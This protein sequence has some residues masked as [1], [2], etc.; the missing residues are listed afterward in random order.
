MISTLYKIEGKGFREKEAKFV[1]RGLS[2]INT[3]GTAI[4][5]GKINL[6]VRLLLSLPQHP[7]WVDA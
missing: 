1:L 6:A 7:H 4:A 2:S 5:S 3:H